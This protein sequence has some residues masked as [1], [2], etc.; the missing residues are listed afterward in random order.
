MSPR[1]E[2]RSIDIVTAVLYF[3]I[4]LI[5]LKLLKIIPDPPEYD[6]NV[7]MGI[8]TLLVTILTSVWSWLSRKFLDIE[9]SLKELNDNAQK[10]D[11]RLIRLEE[12][13]ANIEKNLDLYER[14][15]R[16]EERTKKL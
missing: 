6:I 2:K 4:I 5:V 7:I 13:L 15:V 1:K 8:F 14:I 3:L 9:A 10:F 12:K 16:L 11:K